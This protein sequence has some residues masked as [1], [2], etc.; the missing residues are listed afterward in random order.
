M[1]IGAWADWVN[2]VATA[3]LALIAGVWSFKKGSQ[4]VL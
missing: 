4:V 1:E 3:I 2:V